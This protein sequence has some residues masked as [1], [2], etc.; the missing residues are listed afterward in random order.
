MCYTCKENWN[1]II[2]CMFDEIKNNEKN[3]FEKHIIYKEIA[4]E[5]AQEV[6]KILIKHLSVLF[7]G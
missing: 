1:N 2:I 5:I 3:D 6:E 4:N 7:E